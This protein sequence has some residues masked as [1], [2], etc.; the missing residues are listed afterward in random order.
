MV[1]METVVLKAEPENPYDKNAIAVYLPNERKIGYIPTEEIPT[2]R[3]IMKDEEE[4][5]SA[6]LNVITYQEDVVSSISISIN[7]T[8]PVP[9]EEYSLFSQYTPLEVYRA[10]YVHRYWKGQTLPEEEG[11]FD[12]DQQI[13]HFE[14]LAKLSID[15]RN[16]LALEWMY[17]MNKIQV[18]N[19]TKEGRKMS[20]PLD[21]SVYGTSW[22]DLDLAEVLKLKLIKLESD[23]VAMYISMRRMGNNRMAPDEFIENFFDENDINETLMAR[24]RDIHDNCRM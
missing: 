13:M 21:L 6:T 23:I 9:L 14:K 7:T 15:T 18:D 2:V 12:S 1:Q 19:P 17:R 24:L 5:V 10:N 11:L 20:V 8:L 3:S 16:N 4:E 22:K